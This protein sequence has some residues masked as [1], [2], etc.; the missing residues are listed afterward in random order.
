M[1]QAKQV[2]NIP[3]LFDE[4]SRI[5]VLG[6]FPSIKSREAEFFYGHPQNRYWKV[7][8]VLLGE[9]IPTTVEEKAALMHKHH[10]AM[11]DT[12]GSCTI[13]G[14]AD[15]S[16]TDVVPN[17]LSVIL[18][19]A[20]IEAIFTNGAASTEYYNQYIYPKTGIKPIRLPSTSPANAACSV[21][22]LRKVWGDAL[23]P[24]LD[25]LAPEPSPVRARLL[26]VQDTEYADF[27][28]KLIPNVPPE[29]I[30]GVRTP[31]LRSY[32]K[33]LHRNNPALARQFLDALPHSYF[34]ENQL[35]AFL[36]SEEK[37]YSACIA[38]LKEFLPCVDNWATC[39]Q[40]SPKVLGKHK[41]ELLQ[42]IFGKGKKKGWLEA[43]HAYTV[44][45]GMG[46]LMRWF[47]DEDFS[48]EYLER[49]ATVRFSNGNETD[50]YY[51][52]M[53]IA[54]YFA[55]ALAKQYDAAVP[56]L[57]E[58]RLERWTHNKAI[59]KAV[60]SYRITEEQK[61]YLKTLRKKA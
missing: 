61:A 17:D 37:D 27:Q 56:Y 57:E 49:V 20:P 8:P 33:E 52:N 2:H 9:L 32:A 53:M 44:R 21:V 24:Y 35:H 50:E 45:Y 23:A 60:E 29:S 30:I 51:V 41:E 46:M 31:A 14:S 39:D 43:K 12:I 26:E 34:D 1:E 22:K 6:S 10:V 54:W 18:D 16:I 19:A 36:L 7:M 11:W 28:R 48:Q 55:T 25:L 58:H 4:E 59:Q 38:R 5:L 3:P 15:S 42:E 40:L 47:L 13:T